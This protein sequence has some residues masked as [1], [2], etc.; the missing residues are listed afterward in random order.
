M[1]LRTRSGLDV[2]LRG[3]T[4]EFGSTD[5]MQWRLI[6]DRQPSG[7]N[8]TPEKAVGIPAVLECIRFVSVN[9][10][11][12][13]IV[14][15]DT[16]DPAQATP[17]Y[18][19]W[20]YKLLNF[21]PS[22]DSDGFSMYS[23]IAACMEGYGNA[24]IQKLKA[25]GKVVELRLLDPERVKVKVGDDGGKLFD[26]YLDPK[27][28]KI[29]KDLTTK[30][31]LH[32]RN[33]T[34]NGSYSGLSPIQM[35]RLALGN[36]IALQ[37]YAGRYFANDATPPGYISVPNKMDGANAKEML[38]IWEE[39]HGGI[40]NHGRPAVL[41]EGAEWKE[42]GMN[43]ADALFVEG[44]RFSVEEVCRIMHFPSELLE[45]G[46]TKSLKTEEMALRFL[47]F[48]LM[49]R[50]ERIKAT[51]NN[52]P[53]LF[54]QGSNLKMDFKVESLLRADAVAQATHDLRMRQGGIMTANEIRATKGLPAMEGGDELLAVPVGAGAAGNPAGDSS[55]GDASP[56]SGSADTTGEGQEQ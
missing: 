20:Q 35:E 47:T 44:Q 32:F 21:S 18:N 11:Q 10:A 6:S 38:T 25:R 36:I 8:V 55:S 7:V 31:I 40:A 53:D 48:Y 52:D 1:I 16:S 46:S 19:S 33:F 9:V 45:P 43:I 22:P 28:Q 5:P 29:T 15:Y 42:I 51:F 4:G 30:D 27:A 34:M 37:E 12:L 54:G 39:E 56:D 49:P 26:A 41:W 23:D 14:V 2:E 3:A 50:L 17:A 24:F 13:P